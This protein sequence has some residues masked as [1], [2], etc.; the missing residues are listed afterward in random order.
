M[1]HSLIARY[2]FP[3][4]VLILAVM[5]GLSLAVSYSL[6][7]SYTENLKTRL[8]GEARSLTETMSGLVGTDQASSELEN[9]SI[10]FSRLL[11]ARVTIILPDGTVVGESQSN[12]GEMENHL[13]RPE[14]QAA[15]SGGEG[16]A[17]RISSTLGQQYLYAAV[18]VR[19][20]SGKVIAAARLSMPLTEVD[21]SINS[22]KSGYS[23]CHSDR[24]P[25]GCLIN[26]L[27]CKLDDSS[28]TPADTFS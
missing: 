19:D 12:P 27:D 4:I 17:T 3:Y 18:P 5:G 13:Q 14:I 23:Y 2:A 25:V 28:G 6:R 21:A 8:L 9:K 10:A 26:N 11:G 1:R 24:N 15:L 7:T 20:A 16:T 22:L